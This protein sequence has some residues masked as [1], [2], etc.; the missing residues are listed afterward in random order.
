[1]SAKM[2]NKKPT[3]SNKILA[4]IYEGRKDWLEDIA[5]QI[6][7]YET[8]LNNKIKDLKEINYPEIEEIYRKFYPIADELGLFYDLVKEE[9]VLSDLNMNKITIEDACKLLNKKKDDVIKLLDTFR[10]YDTQG[11]NLHVY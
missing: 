5:E 9:K 4:E 10:K 6:G 7:E 11:Q 8:Y 3:I 2:T 1:M